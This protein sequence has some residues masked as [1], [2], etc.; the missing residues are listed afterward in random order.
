M[1]QS[2]E[3]APD[4]LNGRNRVVLLRRAMEKADIDAYLVPRA[5]EHQGEYVPEC[6]ERLKWL[7]GFSGSAG[8]ALVL[9]DAAHIFVDGRYTLQVRDQTDMNVFTPQST[10]ETSVARWI[11]KNLPQGTR[12]G[13]DPWLHTIAEA[14]ALEDAVH[15]RGGALVPLMKNLVDTIWT[16]RPSPPVEP[17]RIHP[18]KYAGLGAREKLDRLSEALHEAGADACVLTDPS[19]L[20]WTFNIRG[21]DVPHTPLPLGFAMLST[22]DEPTIFIDR[23]KLD[24]ETEAYLTQL[25][26]LMPVSGMTGELVRAAKDEARILLDPALTAEAVRR[27][28]AAAGGTVVEGPDPARLPRAVK[29]EA[30]IAGSRDAHRRDAVALAAFLHWFDSQKPGTLDEITVAKKLEECRE[31][32]GRDHQM[33]LREIAFD[34]ISGAGPNG[35]IVHY[36]VTRKTNRKLGDGELFLLDSGGQYEDGTT[37]IT[38]TLAVGKPTAEMRERFTLVLKGMIAI[39]RARFPAGTRGMDIDALARRALWDRG[40]DYAHG[41][42]HGV[43]S[44]LSVHEG[45]Q[46]ISKRGAQALLPGMILSNEPGYYKAGEY[47]I[48]IENL[49]LVRA[50]EA[51]EGGDIAML[52]FETLTLCPI[53]RR[54]IEPYL[55]TAAELDWLNAYHACVLDEVGPALDGDRLAW[56]EKATA[57]IAAGEAVSPSARAAE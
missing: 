15:K 25:A 52:G 13:F 43:G 41:T 57:P 19:S 1:F 20:A 6:A 5:D 11:G 2:Y 26:R 40:L 35:A 49:V 33:P 22:T 7:T 56:L 48:R 32:A 55:L 27:M 8:T 54:L 30:E 38:R 17:V 21:S 53:D 3:D 18:I 39:S 23:R 46:S 47:G 45:P 42:G 31:K 28:I 29:N 24:I 36:R 50:A 12:L 34:T 16:N 37:D 4:A 14:R 9:A 51:I 44:Y 10:V